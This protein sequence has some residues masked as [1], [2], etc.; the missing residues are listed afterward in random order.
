MRLLTSIINLA[1]T[2]ALTTIEN[3]IPNVS[4]LVKKTDYNT[5]INEIEKKTTDHDH[6]KYITSPEI[7]NSR[8][9][10]CKIIRSKSTEQNC[11]C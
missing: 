8:K 10:C 3:K 6:G 11:H 2:A 9:F 1:K 5:K 7:N 4:N